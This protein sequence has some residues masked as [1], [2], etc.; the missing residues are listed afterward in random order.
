MV[1]EKGS[2][3]ANVARVCD[4][5]HEQRSLSWLFI[6]EKIHSTHADRYDRNCELLQTLTL[7]YHHGY[8]I[9]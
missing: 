5:I 9:I 1:A 6:R 4:R 3:K 7:T 2:A 8:V